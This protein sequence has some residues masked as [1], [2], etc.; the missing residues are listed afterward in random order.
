MFIETTINI[1]HDCLNKISDAARL[2][3]K[4]RT[5]IIIHLMKNVMDV[6]EPQVRCGRSVQYQGK[7]AWDNWRTVHVRFR[8]DDYEYFLDLRKLLKMSVS[9]ILSIAVNKYLK[10]L[11]HENKADNYQVT[12]YVVLKKIING[13]THWILIWGFPPNIEA[14]LDQTAHDFQFTGI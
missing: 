6:R 3:G 14:Y 10:R 4:S 2:S 8:P 1:S 12:N 7:A 9:L 5:E 13:I 11:M